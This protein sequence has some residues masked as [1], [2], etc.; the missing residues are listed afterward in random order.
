[1]GMRRV[2]VRIWYSGN[3]CD[4]PGLLQGCNGRYAIL[5]HSVVGQSSARSW[6][7][8]LLKESY[9]VKNRHA[10]AIKT[11]WRVSW[12][13]IKKSTVEAPWPYKA[14]FYYL[15]FFVFVFY[16]FF[17]VLLTLA[18]DGWTNCAVLLAEVI[19]A[20][21]SCSSWGYDESDV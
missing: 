20:P 10:G 3:D 15:L 5:S 18:R 6:H 8:K 1:M 7:D 16:V 14:S 4:I 11:I 21:Q 19:V 17:M 2:G 9:S 13:A 12:R